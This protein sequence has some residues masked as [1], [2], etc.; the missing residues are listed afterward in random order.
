MKSINAYRCDACD[1]IHRCEDDAISCCPNFDEIEAF[2]CP[3]CK[4]LYEEP[5]DAKECCK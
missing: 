3:S 1:T 5:D 2:E 4:E